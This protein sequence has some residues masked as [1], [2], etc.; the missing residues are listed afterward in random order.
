MALPNPQQVG[1]LLEQ[2]ATNHNRPFRTSVVITK[3]NNISGNGF[4]EALF[5]FK[6]IQATSDS[7]RLAAFTT[8]I[9]NAHAFVW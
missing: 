7:Q 5:K 3:E 6:G 1:Q 8:E 9:N 4:F 2:I